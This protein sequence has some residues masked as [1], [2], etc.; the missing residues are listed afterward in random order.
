MITMINQ[1][2]KY[3]IFISAVIMAGA[4]GCKVEMVIDDID[5]IKFNGLAT[6]TLTVGVQPVGAGT[7][8]IEPAKQKYNAGEKVTLTATANEGY[9]FVGWISGGILEYTQNKYE[10]TMNTNKTYTA[11]FK[12]IDGVEEPLTT[13]VIEVADLPAEVTVAK[14]MIGDYE[15]DEYV[16]LASAN[17]FDGKVTITLPTTLDLKYLWWAEDVFFYY[18]V[19][20]ATV[21]NKDARITNLADPA[22]FAG[23]DDDGDL[24][25]FFLY[26]NSAGTVVDGLFGYA[27]ADVSIAGG[28]DGLVVFDLDMKT[29]WNWVYKIY[30]EEDKFQTDTPAGVNLGWYFLEYYDE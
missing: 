23:L 4:V 27:D 11:E 1:M 20:F 29:G 19:L 14:L 26:G 5:Y 3:L 16:S 25:G 9:E 30:G 6:Y 12:P 22:F 18:G 2:K 17:L 21:S 24:I 15:V 8:H 7:V 13:I 10:I 28:I